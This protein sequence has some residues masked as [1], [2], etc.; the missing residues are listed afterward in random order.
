MKKIEEKKKT[1][2]LEEKIDWESKIN[3]QYLLLNRQKK[4]EIEQVYGKSFNEINIIKDNVDKKYCF[5]SLQGMRNLLDERGY[6]SVDYTI[7]YCSPE[8]V[9]VTCHVTFTPEYPDQ[10]LKKRKYSF[11]ADAHQGNTLS[12]Y[13]NYLTAAAFNRAM[14]LCLRNALKIN[15]VCY[16]E[17]GPNEPIDQKEKFEPTKPHG[18]LQKKLEERGKSFEK[19]KSEWI[20]LGNK[21]A[22][23][24]NSI[25]DIPLEQV[26]VILEAIKKKETK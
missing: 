20:K 15:T 16:E 14:C 21:E 8:F 24:W 10:P 18:F 11:G 2:N 1:Y 7:N 19:F 23:D 6:E 26:W 9:S 12:W 3:P 22:K 5:I 13:G 25:V 17:V 4:D